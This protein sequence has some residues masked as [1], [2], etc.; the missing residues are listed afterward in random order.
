M[1]P[2][3]WPLPWK[4]MQSRPLELPFWAKITVPIVGLSAYPWPTMT[5]GA[6]MNGQNDRFNVFSRLWK[7]ET[8]TGMGSSRNNSELALRWWW[9]AAKFRIVLLPL[10]HL[11]NSSSKSI[12][13]ESLQIMGYRFGGG[14]GGGRRKA[15]QVVQHYFREPQ[16][17]GWLPFIT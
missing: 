16:L 11:K 5:L 17:A 10:D 14:G 3:G 1:F 12:C 15:C 13:N 6:F 2:P 7:H 8:I 4:I 9:V